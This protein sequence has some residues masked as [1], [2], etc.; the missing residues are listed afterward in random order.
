MK[1]AAVQHDIF[2]EDPAANH[3]RL[4]TMIMGAAG[5]GARLIVLP[6]L[7]ATG[8]TTNPDLFEPDEGPTIK[9]LR[10][11]AGRAGSWLC[12]TVAIGVD[13]VAA[14]NACIL[15][16][17]DGSLQRADKRHLAPGR[18]SEAFEAGGR[19]STFTVDDLRVTPIVGH[20]IRYPQDFWEV[21][22]DTDVF[23]VP[24]AEPES[25][26]DHWRTLLGARAIEN[27][28][29]VVGV[30][31][32]GKG[33]GVTYAGDSRIIDPQGEVLAAGAGTETLLVA[34]VES[35]L[36]R[37]TRDR[38]PLLGDRVPTVITLA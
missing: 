11:V 14:A 18:E 13:G 34:E 21:A 16:G 20:G 35:A 15:A 9:F 6:E 3:H 30:N 28:C 12:G 29:Y 22:A 38:T 24:G 27:E 33:G 37:F 31:R 4:E 7:F 10:D 5:A 8:A 1:V 26:R 2:W 36:V 17:P 19:I 25:R 23:V 32:V